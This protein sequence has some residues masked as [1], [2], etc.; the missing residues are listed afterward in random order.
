MDVNVNKKNFF[1]SMDQ[2]NRQDR[3]LV[4]RELCVASEPRLLSRLIPGALISEIVKVRTRILVKRKVSTWSLWK[5]W[6]FAMKPEGDLKNWRMTTTQC[7]RLQ[8]RQLSVTG[9]EF[10]TRPRTSQR[11]S[12]RPRI[13]D[14]NGHVVPRRWL[15]RFASHIKTQAD[16]DRNSVIKNPGAQKH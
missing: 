7:Y 12:M 9:N 13:Y 14:C 10:R 1:K 4:A 16:W 6:V 2:L 15:D 8:P 11:R 3:L 5:L